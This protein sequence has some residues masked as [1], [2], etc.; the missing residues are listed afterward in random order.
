MTA[1]LV[2]TGSIRKNRKMTEQ[3]LISVGPEQ[4]AAASLNVEPLSS[5]ASGVAITLATRLLILAGSLGSSVIV[6]RWLGPEGLG[7]LAV[8]NVTV[9]LASQLG[10][11]GLPSSATYFIAKDR[12]AYAS[13]LANAIGFALAAGTLTA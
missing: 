12:S 9:A 13:V 1:G 3:D 7:A 2:K 8:L 10:G 5:L 4:A 11:A 6:G